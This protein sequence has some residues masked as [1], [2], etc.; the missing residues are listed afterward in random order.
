MKK[1]S[2]YLILI[3]VFALAI[4]A[5]APKPEP[6]PTSEPTATAAPTLIPPT[7]TTLP[8]DLPTEVPPTATGEPAEPTVEEGWHH[9]AEGGFSYKI[10]SGWLVSEFPGLKYKIVT[11]AEASGDV[12][13][14]IVFVD[15]PITG[16]LEDNLD[17]VIEE[18]KKLQDVEILDY[19]SDETSNGQQYYWVVL[20][21]VFNGIEMTQRQFYFELDGVLLVATYSSGREDSQANI[22]IVQDLISDMQFD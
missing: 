8:T 7:A 17:E 20:N 15:G 12:N 10:P 11:S 9:E 14:N 4:S 22:D 3:W 19:G 5:C 21:N 2:K 6:T 1:Y 16:S 13:P 18:L